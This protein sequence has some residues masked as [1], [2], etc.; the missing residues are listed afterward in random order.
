MSVLKAVLG[1]RDIFKFLL[2]YGFILQALFQSKQH[3][4]KEREGF[5]ARSVPLTNRSGRPKICGS[6]SGFESPTCLKGH[7]FARKKYIQ[8]TAVTFCFYFL[9][10]KMLDA[11]P[12]HAVIPFSGEKTNYS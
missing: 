3:Y 6:G 8:Q 7:T 10:K 5:G 2:K 1:I 11:G 12:Q 4:Y 9:F